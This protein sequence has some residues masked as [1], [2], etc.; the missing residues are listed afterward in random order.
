[1]VERM[2]NEAWDGPRA[3]AWD[4]C[5]NVRDLGG[6]PVEDGGATRF[7]QVVRADAVRQLSDEG[8]RAAV[9]YGVSRVVDLRFQSELDADPPGDLPV[10][11]LHVPL[12]P[13]I[14]TPYWADLD[15]RVREMSAAD[16]TSTV[17]LEWLERF[18]E[19]FAEAVAAIGDAPPGAVLVHCQGGRDRTGLVSALALRLAGVPV[20]AV[21]A[22]YALSARNLRERTDAWIAEAPDEAE[23]ERRTRIGESPPEAMEHVVR[24]LE[25]LH[26]SAERYL[27][28]HGAPATALAGLRG[29]LGG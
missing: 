25:R 1:M 17:Y 11:L 15:A 19:R 8:W 27:L 14:D 24:E 5:V 9:A 22:D 28:A 10:E 21:A 6:L 2:S 13:D 20:A 3:L 4:G 26:G 12:L 7:G 23:R 16:A 29:R 18:G